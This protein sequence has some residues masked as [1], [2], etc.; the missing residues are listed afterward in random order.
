[1]FFPKG[2]ADSVYVRLHGDEELYSSG[3]TDKAFERRTTI[4]AW[5]QGTQSAA[6]KTLTSSPAVRKS[7]RDVFVYFD[8]DVKVHAPY[9]AMTLS[10]RLGLGPPPI[11]LPPAGSI[12]EVDLVEWPV[13]GHEV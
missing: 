12:N 7:G 11:E 4:E 10:H 2:T 13:N 9:D 8:N 3:Y 1:M 6:A 5:R